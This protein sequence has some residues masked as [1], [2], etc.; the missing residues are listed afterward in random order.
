MPEISGRE[1][2][3]RLKNHLDQL[4]IEITE[5]KVTMVYAMGDYFMLQTSDGQIQE[6]STV[7][8]STGMIQGKA[9]PG[10]DEFL[11]RGVSYCVTCDAMFFQKKTAAVIGYNH[12]AEEEAD[13]LADIADKVYY[14]PMYKEPPVLKENITVLK[15]KPVEMFGN[16]QIQG[17]RTEDRD[18]ALDGVF[19]IRDAIAPSKLVPGLEMD[20]NHVK[21][22]LKMETNLPGLYAC[23]DIAGTPY[24][25]VKAAGQGN[26]AALS[27]VSYIDTKNKGN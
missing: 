2:A 14:I 27:A 11:G 6:A 1:F 23:G 24:Q 10:E 22:N 15:E 5:K 12:E 19:L 26:V 20:G 4:G 25:Y 16:L 8:L 13:F 17:L 7:I 9:L 3:K 18:I 21:V